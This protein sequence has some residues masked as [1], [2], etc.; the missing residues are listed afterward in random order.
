MTSF[1]GRD[2]VLTLLVHLGYLTYQEKSR[3]A[4]IPNDEVRSEFLR[5]VRSSGWKEVADAVKASEALLPLQNGSI[6]ALSAEQVYRNAF[7]EGTPYRQILFP[8]AVPVSKYN[9]FSRCNKHV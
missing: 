3:R 7:W 9:P 1:R 4:S 6:S 2:D 8:W 5:A